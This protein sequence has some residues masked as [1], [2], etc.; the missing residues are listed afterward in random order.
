MKLASICGVRRYASGNEFVL[1]TA[2][3]VVVVSKLRLRLSIKQLL[4]FL[5]IRRRLKRKH[6]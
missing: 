3:R 1:T 5:A 2:V 6:Q 4:N